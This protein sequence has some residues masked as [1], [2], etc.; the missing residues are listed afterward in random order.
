MIQRIPNT[1]DYEEMMVASYVDLFLTHT[2]KLEGTC[3]CM[4]GR[5]YLT[6]ASF[7]AFQG[8]WNILVYMTLHLRNDM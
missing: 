5:T 2:V 4:F 6:A 7:T 8:M 1:S 3:V